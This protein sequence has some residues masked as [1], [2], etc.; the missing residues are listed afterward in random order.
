[1]KLTKSLE[2]RLRS[3][4]LLLMSLPSAVAAA[5]FAHGAVGSSALL[6]MLVVAIAA[7]ALGAYR[8]L[9]LTRRAPVLFD[10][11]PDFGS[12]A[13]IRSSH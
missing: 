8:L 10:T 13:A 2:S 7:G 11:N 9:S 3:A 5:C 6:A 1:M 4:A 12:T